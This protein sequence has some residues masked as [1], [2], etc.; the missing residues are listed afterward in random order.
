MPVCL[1][2]SH[3]AD[4]LMILSQ[5]RSTGSRVYYLQASTAAQRLEWVNVLRAQAEL[6]ILTGGSV[7][8]CELC[9]W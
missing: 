8:G 5:L 1:P 3:S 7:R 6:Q 2:P 4:F 9:S